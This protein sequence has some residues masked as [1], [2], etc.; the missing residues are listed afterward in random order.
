MERP[1]RMQHQPALDGLRGAAVA[2]VLLFHAGHLRGGYL[3]VDVFFVLSGFLITSLLL[4]EGA[5]TG[6]VALGAFWARRARRLLPALLAVLAFVAVYSLVVA[7]AAER[8]TIRG[9]GLATLGYVANWRAIFSGT[10][11]W[12]LFRSPSPLEHT[13]SLAIEE[14]FYLV[15]PL[16]LV[17]IAAAPRRRAR[18]S[19]AVSRSPRSCGCRSCT[20]PRRPRASTSAPTPGSRRSSSAPRWRR[21][22]RCGAR[23]A[24]V[25]REPPSKSRR[26]VRSCSSRSRG[27]RL[28]GSSTVLYRG[29]LFLTALAVACVIAAA[30]HPQRGGVGRA[31][32]FGPLCALGLISYGVY[33]WHWPIY[34]WLDTQRTHLDGWALVALRIAV[35][36]AVA[37]LSYFLLEQ[38]IRHGA[39]PARRAATRGTGAGRPARGRPRVRDRVVVTRG[40]CRRGPDTRRDAA[41][42]MSS[43]CWWSGTRSRCSSPTRA[44]RRCPRT[45]ASTC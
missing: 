21:G 31:L 1:G 7:S 29:G 23:G 38:P 14:Q 11:Y 17:A 33:L 25:A 28:D 20:T 43:G 26:G 45:R 4:A 15:W 27:S 5:R 44:S 22:S 24:R 42:P 2:G 32:S 18:R 35:T 41:S 12:A 30:V 3:G 13:W 8:T 16:L 10:D 9:D 39:I 6:T 19:R 36:I 37:T 34:V 40:A